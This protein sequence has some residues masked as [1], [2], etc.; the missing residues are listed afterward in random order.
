MEDLRTEFQEGREI[1]PVSYCWRSRS[2]VDPQGL[3]NVK[4]GITDV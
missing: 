1:I 2:P 3:T 4:K